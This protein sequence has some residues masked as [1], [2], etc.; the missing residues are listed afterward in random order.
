M[1]MCHS[2]YPCAYDCKDKK[3]QDK[4]TFS[5]AQLE[6]AD[7]CKRWSVLA[8][9][10]KGTTPRSVWA[11]CGTLTERKEEKKETGK[12]KGIGGRLGLSSTFI[13]QCLK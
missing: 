12:W 4:H 2:T 3:K 7:H 9:G 1:S 11:R 13:E 5:G 10:N 6:E 8:H